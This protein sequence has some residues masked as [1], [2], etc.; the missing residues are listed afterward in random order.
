[1]IINSTGLTS[2]IVQGNSRPAQENV[3]EIN[4]NVVACGE[5]QSQKG[6]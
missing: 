6:H 4:P 5:T 2:I 1:M 3:W